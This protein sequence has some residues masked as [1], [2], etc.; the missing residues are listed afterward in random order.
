MADKRRWI[1]IW[2]LFVANALNYVDRVNISVAG[3]AI[4]KAF[5]LGPAAMGV[6]FSCFFYSYVL[7]ILPMGMLADRYGSRAVSSL[8]MAVWSVGAMLTGAVDGFGALIAARLLL[9]AGESSSY[10]TGNRIVREWSLRHERGVATSIFNMGSTLGPAIGIVAASALIASAGWRMSFF[11][12]GGL[13]LVWTV[14]WATIYRSPER[15]AWLSDTERARIVAE[16]EPVTAAPVTPMSVKTLLKKKTMW[17]LLLT[18]GCQ[19]Y[20]IYLFLTWLPSYLVNV[21]GL[22]MISAGWLGM[23]PYVAGSVGAVLVGL[24]S[25]RMLRGKDLSSG[26]RRKLMI[27]LMLLALCVAAIP[28]SRSLVAL[29]ALLILSV[30]FISG[31]NTLNFALTGDMIF[32]R[33][34]AGAV[35]GLLVLG[36][37]FFGFLAPLLTGYIIAATHEYTL[38]FALAGALLL[39]G[40]GLSMVLVTEPLQPRETRDAAAELERS[41]AAS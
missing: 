22:K 35:Y 20:S 25:D 18:H 27:V 6:V 23:L 3:P 38:S 14:A 7:L 2:V 16:R 5:N 29:E 24:A 32:D 12:L 39:V 30:L 8:G 26:A 37:N 4:A 17:G 28:F 15:A 36:G 21:R 34:S 31:A 10:P 19:T 9:G 1:I 40:A 13:T 41:A 11:V 33:R